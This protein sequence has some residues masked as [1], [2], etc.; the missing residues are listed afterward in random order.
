MREPERH[1]PRDDERDT[2]ITAEAAR[3]AKNPHPEQKRPRCSDPGPDRVG[4]ADRDFPLCE[5]EQQTAAMHTTAITTPIMSL[6][7]SCAHFS[8]T[9]QPI[10]NKPAVIR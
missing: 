1:D 4:G 3:I 7:G 8:P 5:V 2:K 9:G 6:R 10:S